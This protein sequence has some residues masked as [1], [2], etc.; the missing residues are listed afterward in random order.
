[1]QQLLDNFFQTNQFKTFT[2]IP[3]QGVTADWIMH[4]SKI[5]YLP[6]LL[7]APYSEML[8]EARALDELY[9]QH[10]G[11]DSNGWASLSVHGITSQHTD[12]YQTYPEYA[13][14]DNN[15]VPY[16]WTEVS[17]RCPAT[18]AYFKNV[19]PY[20]VYHRVRFMRLSPGGYI[21]PHNDS[22]DLGLRAINISL[23]N[24]RHCDFVFDNIGCVPFRNTGSTILL[25]N[26]YTHAVWNRSTEDRYHIIVHGYSTTDSFNDV[27]VKS[28]QSLA[29]EVV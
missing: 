28:Y 18:T 25:A 17:D 2:H 9:V 7:D 23:N 27:L 1:M 12:H 8:N 19:F 11:T 16:C 29:P 3:V 5:P 14:L 24:P 10:R 26:G 15:S 13:D 21:V 4:N 22:T 20:D 6:L